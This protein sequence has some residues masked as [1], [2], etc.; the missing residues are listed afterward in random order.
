[1]TAN[2]FLTV[3]EEKIGKKNWRPY[4]R[5]RKFVDRVFLP[6]SYFET[7]T[8]FCLTLEINQ[9]IIKR[10]SDCTCLAMLQSVACMLTILV[11]F[12]PI[13]IRNGLLCNRKH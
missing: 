11:V 8:R 1:M 3:S 7:V 10:N 6:Q 9:L 5:C 2:L 4:Q 12:V 13:T